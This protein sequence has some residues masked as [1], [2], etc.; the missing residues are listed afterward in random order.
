MVDYLAPLVLTFTE[1]GMEVTYAGPRLHN[2]EPD[3]LTAEQVT[4]TDDGFTLHGTNGDVTYRLAGEDDA[5]LPFYDR[6]D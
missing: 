4:V 3:H 1:D 6:Q 2:F 5:G